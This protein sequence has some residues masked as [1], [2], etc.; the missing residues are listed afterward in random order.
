MHIMDVKYISTEKHGGGG[1]GWRA[2]GRALW[3]LVFLIVREGRATVVCRIAGMRS[4]ARGGTCSGASAAKYGATTLSSMRTQPL[5]SSVREW[6]RIHWRDLPS[7]PA[8]TP[9]QTSEASHA[10]AHAPLAAPPPAPPPPPPPLP[11]SPDQQQTG[12]QLAE[13]VEGAGRGRTRSLK[14]NRSP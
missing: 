14:R 11:P 8:P 3:C 6:L 1:G 9:T 5:P 12:H 7:S 10:H 13:M 2:A 4:V